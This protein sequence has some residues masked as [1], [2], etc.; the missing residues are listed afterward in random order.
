MDRFPFP[1]P[2]PTVKLWFVPASEEL[3]MNSKLHMVAVTHIMAETQR[4]FKPGFLVHAHRCGLSSARQSSLQDPLLTCKI[5]L[6]LIG[7]AN[8]LEYI[9]LSRPSILA[10]QVVYTLCQGCTHYK[11]T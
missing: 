9:R 5:M 8:T 2:R 4:L 10:V 1:F 6:S 11:H 7:C 3:V